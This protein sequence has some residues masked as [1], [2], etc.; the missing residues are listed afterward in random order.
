MRKS[1]CSSTTKKTPTQ[2]PTYRHK[3][4]QPTKNTQTY[5]SS[6]PYQCS[7]SSTKLIITS[8]LSFISP[9]CLLILSILFDYSSTLLR[10]INKN[11]SFK[12]INSLSNSTEQ[13]I[14]CLFQEFVLF[15]SILSSYSLLSLF[16]R[17]IIRWS[18]LLWMLLTTFSR[19]R[20]F[21][22]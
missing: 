12:V 4:L 11:S 13:N 20:L 5:V 2:K 15:P 19:C 7:P 14:C 22:L 17:L 8:K 18:I 9:S 1:T 6:I 16:C 21:S 3:P 10:S